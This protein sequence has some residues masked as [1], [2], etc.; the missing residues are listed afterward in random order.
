M[1]K[2]FTKE[3]IIYRDRIILPKT[4]FKAGDDVVV[5]YLTETKVGKVIGTP[6]MQQSILNGSINEFIPIRFEDGKI[7]SPPDFITHKL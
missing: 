7:D 4:D 2:F 3:K 1:I 6:F 5:R